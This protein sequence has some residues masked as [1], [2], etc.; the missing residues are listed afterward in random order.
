M[1]ASPA[2]MSP[3][4]RMHSYTSAAHDVNFN[5][6]DPLGWDWVSDPLLATSGEAASFHVPLIVD[7]KVPGTWFDG[8]HHVWRTQD[9][10][11][12]QSDLDQHCNEF[13]GDF[14][15]PCCDWV[16]LGADLTSAAYG[17]DKGGSYVVAITRAPNGTS[18]I[19]VATRRGRLFV[20]GN[21]DAPAANVIFTRLDTSKQPIRFI[22]GIA[23]DP[24]N[25]NRAFVSFSGY[26]AYTPT[27]PGHV[28]RGEPGPER[29]DRNLE[30][31]E[32]QHR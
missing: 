22:S 4:I 16:P 17:L 32:L 31:P 21:A 6:N 7:P 5:T 12:A 15:V 27:T 1:E 11:G 9:N 26:N 19:W 3:K 13:F 29:P 20:S 28:F 25:A 30:G 23:V 18:T 2:L 8:L 14:S 10:G 24:A